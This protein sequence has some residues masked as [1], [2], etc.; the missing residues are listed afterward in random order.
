VNNE[1]GKIWKEAIL[2]FWHISGSDVASILTA[3]LLNKQMLYGMLRMTLF[4]GNSLVG[5]FSRSLSSAVAVGPVV[6]ADTSSS[7]LQNTLCNGG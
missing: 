5:L 4:L 2:V 1:V 6:E 3:S 7:S